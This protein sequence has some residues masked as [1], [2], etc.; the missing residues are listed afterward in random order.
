MNI[1]GVQ[2]GQWEMDKANNVAAGLL[3][4]HPD[5]K[6]I[7]CANDSM[8]LGA[9][10]AVASAGRTGKVLVVGFDNIGAIQP[11]IE[12]GRVV[13]TAD[14]HGGELAVFGIEAALSI[15]AG[16]AEPKDKTTAVDLIVKQ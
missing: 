2:S 8:A 5:L 6:A 15:L 9:V 14:Q 12:D 1:V 13:A 4:E 10:S 16:E 7:L 11:M 3:S